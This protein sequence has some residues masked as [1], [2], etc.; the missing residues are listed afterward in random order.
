ML[1]NRVFAFSRSQVTGSAFVSLLRLSSSVAPQVPSWFNVV[2]KKAHPYMELARLD[3]PIGTW[4][5]YLPSAWSIAIAANPGCL[6][7][8]GMLALFGAGA[9]LMRG[10]GCTVNDIIDRDIDMNVL[11]TRDRPVARGSISMSNAAKF[12]VLQLFGA[13]VILLQLNLQTMF[14]GSCC[15]GPVFAYPLFKRFTYWSQIMLGITL[16]WGALMGYSAIHAF[17]FSIC[18]P[19]YLAG[20]C[21]TVLYDSIYSFQDIYYDKRLGLKSMPILLGDSSKSWLYGLATGMS[22]CLVVTGLASGSG[23]AYFAGTGLTMMRVFYLV[24][25]NG[26]LTYFKA[27]RDIGLLLFASIALDRFTISPV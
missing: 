25:H 5:V 9:L 23:L 10:A 19:L 26:C 18:L 7:D 4:L 1:L 12:L 14:I 8:C 2:P 15:L 11:R 16:N 24:S 17:D 20:V 3:K 13:L 27:N 22:A 21:Q 6:P